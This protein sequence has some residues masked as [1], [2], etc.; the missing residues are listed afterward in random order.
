MRVALIGPRGAGKSSVAPALASHYGCP[1]LD[2]DEAIET[3]VGE[4]LRHFI[5]RAG[6]DAFRVVELETC[7]RLLRAPSFVLACGAGLIETPTARQLLHE[8]TDQCLWLDLSPAQQSQRL[9]NQDHRPALQPDL[10]SEQEQQQTDAKRRPLYAALATRCIDAS[11][12]LPQV[13]AAC[14]KD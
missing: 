12:S 14:L 5:A 9:G 13:I 8:A 2:L 7:A 1:C 11:A 10:T 4:P 6:W 3:V